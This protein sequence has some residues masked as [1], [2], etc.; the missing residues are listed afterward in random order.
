MEIIPVGQENSD[1]FTRYCRQFGPE[2]DPSYTMIE[3]FEPAEDRPAYVLME[4]GEAAGAVALFVSEEYRQIRRTRILIFHARVA[5]PV[6]YGLLL[7]AISPHLEP[8][9]SAYLFI[10]AEK[11][12]T[13]SVWE[14]LGFEIERVVYALKHEHIE[15]QAPVLP[16]GFHVSPI[17]PGNA[18]ALAHYLT[19][20]N[21]NYAAPSRTAD[22]SREEAESWF[23]EASYLAGGMMLLWCGAQP[24]GTISVYRDEE[25]EDAAC[26]EHVSVIPA[27]R[28]RGLG[29]F[30]LRRALAFAG[31]QGLPKAYLTVNAHNETALPLYLSEGFRKLSEVICYNI[32][33]APH[34]EASLDQGL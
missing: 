26:I 24:V 34:I 7:E 2:H 17:E 11:S 18:V 13:R 3:R 12:A 32:K 29:R 15:V 5:D 28:G 6:R 19:L 16:A 21:T 9:D 23:A 8:F 27:Y 10:P 31:E 25:E 4:K 33:I 22:I 14:S 20:W 1:T 30:L